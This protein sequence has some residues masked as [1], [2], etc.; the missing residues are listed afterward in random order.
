MFPIIYH[1]V[2]D[3]TIET[4]RSPGEGNGNPLLYSCLE[5]PMDR[6]AWRATVYGVTKNRIWLKRHGSHAHRTVKWS[7]TARRARAEKEGEK[8]DL[9]SSKTVLYYVA[10]ERLKNLE[11]CRARRVNSIVCKDPRKECW[12]E[13]KRNVYKQSHRRGWGKRCYPKETRK[14]SQMA[15]L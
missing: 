6:G 15:Q 7:E 10:M 11:N 5:N 4:V 14:A 1:P 2:K 13:H 3:K 9:Q 12:S 8:G